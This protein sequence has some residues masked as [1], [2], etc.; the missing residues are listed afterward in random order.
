MTDMIFCEEIT[1]KMVI[2]EILTEKCGIDGIVI[3][4]LSGL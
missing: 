1:D 4:L 2:L 3:L